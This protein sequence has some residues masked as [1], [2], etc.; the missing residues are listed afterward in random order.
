MKDTM[1]KFRYPGVTPFSTDQAGIFRGREQDKR[2]LYRLIK[3][4]SLVV[5][6]G[7]SGLGKSSLINAG[8]I[9]S[10]LEEGIYTPVMVRFGAFSSDSG[11]SDKSPV[12]AVME[13]LRVPNRHD[14]TEKLVPDD[15]SVWRMVKKR[16]L[17]GMNKTLL[18]FDQ[19][20]E[21]F[22]YPDE[23]VQELQQE[24]AELLYINVPLR[25]RRALEKSETITEEEEELLEDP[26]ETRIL[27]T[28]RSDRMHYLDRLKTSLKEVLQNCFELKP[29][30]KEDALAAIVE[31]A[32]A[33]GDFESP[34]FEYSKPAVDKLL[35]YLCDGSEERVE[36]I[37]LQMLCEHYEREVVIGGNRQYL[38][39]KDIGDPDDVVSNYYDKKLKSFSPSERQ[40][41]CLLI[42]EGLISTG[43]DKTMRLSL[44]EDFIRQEYK[45]DRQ[46]LERLVES[47]L[48]RPEPFL[49]G[50]YTYE[51]CHDRL[52]SPVLR[53][54]NTRREAEQRA[55][56][57]R[58]T[59]IFVLLASLLA[60]ATAFS[61][62]AVNQRDKANEA[63]GKFRQEQASRKEL[64]FGALE[65]RASMILKVGGCPAAILDTMTSIAREHPDSTQFKNIIGELR[66][67]NP[68]CQ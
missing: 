18:I 63:L 52:M 55:R 57:R 12:D 45:V 56:N 21:L 43:D 31:P 49:R 28:I 58:N 25:Y 68:S 40:S 13:A 41:A 67:Q 7:K 60:G 46:L 27:F 44:H 62:W 8:I 10:C 3:Q 51:L 26:L 34:V 37:M 65:A 66:R 61:V 29:L 19:F 30:K 24:L 47:R 53:A 64:E 11:G 33:E 32:L 59:V 16:Q 20:E 35:A 14:L 38:S 22:S 50:G 42:E 2:D 36:G 39:E 54:R 4:T 48:L 17:G 9:P 15:R 5:L 23:M 1:K 6:Y